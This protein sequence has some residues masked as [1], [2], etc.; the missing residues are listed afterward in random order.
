MLH[1]ARL[2]C[3]RSQKR[4]MVPTPRWDRAPGPG[5]W[6]TERSRGTT[7]STDQTDSTLE[8]LM[9]SLGSMTGNL[10]GGD[11]LAGLGA[12]VAGVRVSGLEHG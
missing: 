7:C 5:D 1:L 11:A 8:E 6:T 10:L 3:P 9:Q 4:W 12:G 2:A